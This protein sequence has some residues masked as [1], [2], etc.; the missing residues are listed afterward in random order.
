MPLND[1]PVYRGVVGMDG[2]QTTTIK[3][4]RATWQRLK[5]KRQ[6]PRETFDDTVARLCDQDDEE[7]A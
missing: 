6:H 5:N 2:T 1:T 3:I 4:R 7:H